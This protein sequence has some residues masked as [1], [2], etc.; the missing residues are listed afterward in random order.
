MSLARVWKKNGLR[1]EAVFLQ[2]RVVGFSQRNVPIAYQ[3]PNDK[4][5]WHTMPH[6]DLKQETTSHYHSKVSCLLFK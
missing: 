2:C 1:S 5:A 4:H 3:F 6:Q